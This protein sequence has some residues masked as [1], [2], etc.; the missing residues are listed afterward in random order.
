MPTSDSED[1]ESADEGHLSPVKKERKKR[2]SSSNYSDNAL[3]TD[4]KSYNTQNPN[5]SLK[6]PAEKV[7]CLWESMP[8][9][10]FTSKLKH[11][12]L[13][14]FLSKLINMQWRVICI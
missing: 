11:K 9:L 8:I 10:Y 5:S 13:C 1:F 3:E 14:N 7:T 6:K 4:Q 2:L 12:M